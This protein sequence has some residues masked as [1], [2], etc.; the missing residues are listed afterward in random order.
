MPVEVPGWAG[1]IIAEQPYPVVF[2][3]VS[4]AHLYGFASVD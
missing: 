4:G 1:E 3:M 2:A